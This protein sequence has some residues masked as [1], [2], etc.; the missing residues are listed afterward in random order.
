MRQLRVLTIILLC[1]LPLVTSSNSMARPKKRGHASCCK[2]K[3]CCYENKRCCK[4]GNH[5]C[6]TGKHTGGQGC[7]CRKG[8]CP[9]PE[10]TGMTTI[11]PVKPAGHD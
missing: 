6:C 4:K 8:S 2:M 11:N 3:H 1:A 10:S 5:A 9:M 7:C